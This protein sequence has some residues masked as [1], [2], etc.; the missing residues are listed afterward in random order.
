MDARPLILVSNRGPVGFVADEDGVLHA[1]RSG[2]GLVTA[3]TGLIDIVPAEWISAAIEPGDFRV[4]HDADGPFPIP[5]AGTSTTGRFVM[6]DPDVYERYYNVVANPML[7]FI[8]HYLWDLSNVPD[9]REEE[10]AAWHDGYLVA[11]DLFADA[12]VESLAQNP[13]AV[14][15]LHDYHLYTAPASIRA[16]VPDAFLHF[17]VHIPW[18][19]PDYWRVLPPHIRD[20]VLEGLLAC[21]IVAFHTPR[22][23]RN[24]LLSCEDLL[25]LEVDYAALTVRF[26]GRTVAVR[27]Y[28]I[29]IDADGF[30][31]MATGEAV[32]AEEA[33]FL[34]RRRRH[35]VVRV[36]R[37][38]LS[39]N[40]LRGF[41]AFDV[42][43]DRHPEFRE[44]ITFFAM[45]QAS[46]QDVPEYVE[47]VERITALVSMINTKHGNTDW[48]PIELRFESNL[49]LAITAYKHF[50]VMIV[51]SIFDGMNLVAKESMLVNER[52]G[53]LILSENVGAFEEIGA[54]A[55]GVNPF[56]IEAQAEALHQALTMPY[57]ERRAR[58]DAIRTV[59]NEND[60]AKWLQAQV[61]D[62]EELRGQ[63]VLPPGER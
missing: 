8:Q 4:A 58:G 60:I 13:G 16:R 27:H 7:W 53:V 1:E 35:L 14:V 50:D 41:T 18:P 51:N 31:Q 22:Y 19:Q 56:D 38:D 57:A 9:I 54:Y 23:A 26:G 28:P 63:A 59:I 3:L 11:N 39:K 45:L 32:Q 37:T 42:F 47:Y 5:D 10:L 40:I 48:M 6:I 36:D 43:L 20:A 49:P 46:R 2:G 12:V 44:D 33:Q 52:D 62:I 15:M 24:F 25:G 17:F 34:R 21:D 29:S 30:T 55:L 61:A